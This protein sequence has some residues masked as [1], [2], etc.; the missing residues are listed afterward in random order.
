MNIETGLVSVGLSTY[1]RLGCRVYGAEPEMIRLIAESALSGQSQEGHL[2]LNL[3]SI[4][5]AGGTALYI[6]PESIFG[7]H[8]AILGSTGGGKSWTVAR[9]MEQSIKHHAKLV[10]LDATG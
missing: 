5:A 2:T 4:P 6:P 10:L 7:R 9:V 1:P 8:C 3:A